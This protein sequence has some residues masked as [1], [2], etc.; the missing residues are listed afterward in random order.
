MEQT[1]EA[2]SLASVIVNVINDSGAHVAATVDS[3]TTRLQKGNAADTTWNSVV[4]T[5]DT[6]T[7]GVYRISFS[8]LSP[9]L[10]LEDNDEF[11]RIKINGSID[12]GSAWTEY[13]MPLRVVPAA[14]RAV[15]KGEVDTSLTAATTSGFSTTDTSVEPYEGRTLVFTSGVNKHLAVKITGTSSVSGQMSIA[16]ETHDGSVMPSA[17]SDGDTFE[18]V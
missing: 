18:V 15:V 10:K 8:G 14:P 7:T 17:P 12:G 13:H 4:P 16:V 5:I 1:V 6:I 11:V 9:E 2:G 3:S